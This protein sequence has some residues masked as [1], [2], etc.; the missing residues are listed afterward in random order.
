MIISLTVDELYPD[1]SLEHN[2]VDCDF[3]GLMQ[4]DNSHTFD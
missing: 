3:V 2:L 1:S 4:V